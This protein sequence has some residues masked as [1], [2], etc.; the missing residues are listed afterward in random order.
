[1]GDLSFEGGAAGMLC[2]DA[3]NASHFP[4]C[5]TD[6]PRRQSA[7]HLAKFDIPGMFQCDTDAMGLGMGLY[8]GLCVLSLSVVY[9]AETSAGKDLH[10]TGGRVGINFTTGNFEGGSLT[11]VDSIFQHV[12]TAILINQSPQKSKEQAALELL[13]VGYSDVATV[14]TSQNS[15]A[16]LAGGSSGHIDSWLIGKTFS[17]ETQTTGSAEFSNGK[18]FGSTGPKIPTG[19]LFSGPSGSGYF[20]RSRPQYETYSSNSFI[21]PSLHGMETREPLYY[22]LVKLTVC[23]L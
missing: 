9:H 17:Q 19:L 20:T 10:I 6:N 11:V 8:V 18:A 12:D 15:G 13:N 14:V 16:K 7:I 5:Y 22:G 3:A 23:V 2:K 4:P 1:M 21:V